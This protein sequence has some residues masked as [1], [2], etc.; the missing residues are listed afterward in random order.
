MLSSPS[1]NVIKNNSYQILQKTLVNCKSILNVGASTYTVLGAG[2]WRFVPQDSH[3]TTLDINP[4]SGADI[5]CD[6]I[7][8]PVD[9]N[10]FDLVV[11]QASAE[12]FEDLDL[13]LREIKRVTKNSGY[14]YFTVPFLQGYHADPSDFRRFTS[15]G[16]I[17]KMDLSCIHHGIS[18]GPFSVI[19]WVLR[20]L[21]TFG[22][23]GSNLY[24]VSRM[25][26]SLVFVP[27]SYID[28]IF[29]RTA[30]YERNACEFFYLF[31]NS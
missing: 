24:K 26:S 1:R 28:F 3:I 30:A 20:D 23:R 21:M 19:S 27:I 15:Q 17:R 31:Q 2:F 29:P 8:I 11:C 6:V 10:S 12:H 14:L 5:I 7:S 25:F 16:F 4:D 9:N 13:A 18:S 22:T